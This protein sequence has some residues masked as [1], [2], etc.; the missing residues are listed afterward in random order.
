[1]FRDDQVPPVDSD[2]AMA[3]FVVQSSHI[4]KSNNTV[5][6]DAFIPHPHVELSLTRH[7]E[8]TDDELWREG[9]R[10]AAIRHATLHGR[11]D[12]PARAFVD[13][14]LAV[15]AKPIPKNP[16]H[17]DVQGWPADKPAQK[18][19]ATEIAIKSILVLK[20]A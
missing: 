3:R 7:R 11:A 4:R 19:K 6:P 2:E 10:V 16:N 14:G 8:A 17:A 5:K 18:M 20:P 9:E 12:V 13:E 1:M 15:V